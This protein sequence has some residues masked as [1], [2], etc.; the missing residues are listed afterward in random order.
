MQ[1]T[2]CEVQWVNEVMGGIIGQCFAL[3]G[4]LVGWMGEVLRGLRSSL[5]LSHYA[6]SSSLRSKG[7]WMLGGRVGCSGKDVV[8]KMCN[9]RF[10]QIHSTA[11]HHMA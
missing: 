11:L 8:V 2:D 6:Q 1:Q 4:G 9:K 5:P 10:T 3:K 7:D